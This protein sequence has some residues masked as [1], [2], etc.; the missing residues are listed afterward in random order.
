[1]Y[2]RKRGVGQGGGRQSEEG[3]SG[4]IKEGEKE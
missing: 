3:G 1:M 4:R 2:E